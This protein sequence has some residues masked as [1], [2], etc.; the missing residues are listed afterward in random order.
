MGCKYSVAVSSG[1]AALCLALKAIDIKDREVV[2]TPFSFFASTSSIIYANGIPIFVDIKKSDFNIDENLIEKSITDNTKVILP[3]SLFGQYPNVDKIN[4]IAKEYNLKVVYDNCQAHGA[5]FMGKRF[6]GDI[7]CYSFYPTKNMTTGE[8]GMVCTNDEDIYNKILSLR[9]HGQSVKHGKITKYNHNVISYNYRMTDIEA[10]IGL[11]QLGILDF[12]NGKRFGNAAIYHKHLVRLEECDL[13]KL[14]KFGGNKLNVFN[15][16]SI[17]LK[18]YE[19]RDRL[20]QIL[21][22]NSIG[23]GVY[24]DKLIP[25]NLCFKGLYNIEEY[26]MA[27]NISTRIISLPV[28]P[29]L[30]KEDIEYIS[31]VVENGLKN[32]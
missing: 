2:T 1:T 20:I 22:D 4:S 26:L 28:H 13:V 32:G 31:K 7:C 29:N 14:P 19:D 9:N 15:Q 6:N 30:N 27:K 8:G 10:N 12:L 3:V 5:E 17:L 18:N 11:N 25:E 16:Y 21:K 24:Y 23:Y